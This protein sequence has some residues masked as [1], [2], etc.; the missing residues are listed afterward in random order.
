MILRR[1]AFVFPFR[2]G[3]DAWMEHVSIFPHF[4]YLSVMKEVAVGILRVDGRVLACQRKRNAVYPLKWEFPGGK[5][6]AGESPPQA[7]RRELGEEL[8]IDATPGAEIHRQ[9]WVYAEGVANPERDGSF[10]VFYYLVDRYTGEPANHAFEEIR[11]VTVAE[12][13]RL[14]MLEGN[15]EAVDILLKR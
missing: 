2:G 12:L 11:W 14:D 4:S 15:R 7:L 9:E 5:V 3:C 1:I 10:R 6:E 13:D 8:G